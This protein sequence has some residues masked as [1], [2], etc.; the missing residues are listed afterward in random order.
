MA[1][2]AGAEEQLGAT[3]LVHV[4]RDA[5]LLQQL[6]AHLQRAAPLPVCVKQTKQ[7]LGKGHRDLCILS[8]LGKEWNA[9]CRIP[10]SPAP[11]RST[12]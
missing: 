12:W 5:E 3:D 7:M 1:Q 10:P 8:G 11:C 6:L 4:G 2:H 9:V